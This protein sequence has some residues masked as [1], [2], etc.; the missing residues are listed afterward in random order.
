MTDHTAHIE[1]ELE[2]AS[3][4]KIVAYTLWFGLFG[5]GAHR[6]YLGRVFSGLVQLAL[7]VTWMGA[8]I[9]AP[10]YFALMDPPA[11]STADAPT[12]LWAAA[13]IS[14]AILVVWIVW[15]VIDAF[16]IPRWVRNDTDQKRTAIE[17]RYRA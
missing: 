11:A 1:N 10:F 13:L 17:A 9:L 5:C 6:M 14:V 2:Y 12:G 16:F 7:F 15:A 3:K 8:M 4:S